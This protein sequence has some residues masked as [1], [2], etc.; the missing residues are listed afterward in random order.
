MNRCA[1][2]LVLSACVAALGL[3]AQAAH[4]ATVQYK[5]LRPTIFDIQKQLD[6]HAKDGWRLRAMAPAGLCQ[7]NPDLPA[8]TPVE[9]FL[10]VLERETKP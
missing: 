10:I 2:Q 5:V 9:C 4:A 6:A 7:I 3:F 1:R 8:G